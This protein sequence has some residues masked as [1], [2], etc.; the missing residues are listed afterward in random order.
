MR[1]LLVHNYY[2][3]AGGEDEVFRNEAELLRSNGHQVFEYVRRNDEIRDYGLWDKLAMSFRT[4]WAHKTTRQLRTIL[5]EKKPQVAHLHNT[6]P[7]VSPTAY[8][9]CATAG[10]P[11]VQT[12]H[13]YRLLCPAG[14]FFRDG[15]I[16]EQCLSRK[17]PWP[18]VLHSCYRDSAPASFVVAAMLTSHYILGSWQSK[19]DAYIAISEFARR[20]FIQGG[21]PAGRIWVK[22]NFVGAD[23]EIKDGV[24]DY[25][26]FIGR[27]SEE[28]GLRVLLKAWSCLKLK[29]PLIVAGVGPMSGEVATTVEKLGMDRIQLLGQVG[30][31]RVVELL[32]HARFLVFPSVWYEGAFPLSI[33]EA[34][35]S[36][37]PVIA[38]RLGAMEEAIADGQ[39][40]L[41]FSC[42]DPADLAARVEWAWT[43]AE[44]IQ[45]MGRAARLEYQAKYTPERNYETLMDIYRS[46]I[47]SRA[48]AA[49]ES[50]SS[51]RIAAWSAD[52]WQ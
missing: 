14:T 39:T 20:K 17:A 13:N 41:L 15:N 16:C 8:Y 27:L 33:I 25:A 3:N 38:S 19:V 4:A 11:V 2:Q 44:E 43:H 22:P 28:K 24:G 49:G 48:A 45:S 34:F 12:L 51:R 36:G 30:R 50:P 23:P 5:A 9:A 1:C 52:K 21:L 31:T 10:V 6:F 47:A 35:A 37:L 18:A 40:G 29:I 32:R 42:G 46:A 7:L 26:L